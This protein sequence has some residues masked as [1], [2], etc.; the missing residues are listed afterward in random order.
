MCFPRW[1]VVGIGE[2]LGAV[3][4]FFFFL[5]FLVDLG[6]VLVLSSLWTTILKS[7]MGVMFFF[8]FFFQNIF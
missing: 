6:V 3:S 5:F 7:K 2:W 1:E 4:R 8:L